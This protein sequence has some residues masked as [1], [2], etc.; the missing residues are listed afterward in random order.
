MSKRPRL[1]LIQSRGMG[2]IVIA[3]PIARHYWEEGW[4]IVW[5]ICEEFVSSFEHTVPWVKW[6]PIPTDAQGRFFWEVP[7]QRLKNLGVDQEICLYQHLTGHEFS[8]EPYFQYTS[9]DQYKYI[10]A[11]VPFLKKWQLSDCVTRSSAREQALYDRVVRNPQYAVLHLEGSDHR[12]AFDTQVIPAEWQIIEIE[13]LTDCIWDWLGVIEGAESIVMVDSVYANIVD[14]LALGT[15]RYFIPRSHIG[16][17]PVQG[18]HWH[19][20]GTDVSK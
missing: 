6:V 13:P 4:D 14:Q 19:W 10:R 5:P 12:A 1:G 15:D 18:Q 7:R 3:L 16:L 11:G 9:F 20:I 17:T 8:Q 2:D